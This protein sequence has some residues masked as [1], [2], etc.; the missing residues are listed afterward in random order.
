MKKAS[1][2]LLLLAFSLLSF[3]FASTYVNASAVNA[4]TA[5]SSADVQ[6]DQV[7][8]TIKIQEGALVVINDTLKLSPKAGENTVS[9]Q[10]FSLGFPFQ[11]G[12]NLDYCFAYEASDPDTWLDVELDTGLGRLGFYGVTVVFP[13]PG[14]N[15]GD[16][17][18]YNLTVIFVF[19]NLVSSETATL[20]KLDFPMY[21]SLTQN[22]SVC[23]VTVILPP[24]ASFT[25]S[26][27]HEKELDFNITTLGDSQIL[28]HPKKPS[29]SFEYEPAWLSF[30]MT[31]LTFPI[32]EFNEIEREIVLDQWGSIHISNSYSITNRGYDISNVKVGFPEGA[33]DLAVRDEMGSIGKLTEE[34]TVTVYLRET[35]YK[36]EAGKF[37]LSYH[38]PW[39]KYISHHNRLNYDLNFSFFERF[40]WTIGKLTV[41]IT[42]PQGA[43]FQSSNPLSPHSIEK[44][45]FQE[46]VTFAFFNVTPFEDLNFDVTYGYLV[47]WASF[48]P[49]LWMGVLII[50]ASAIA[51][52]WRAPKPPAVPMV[53]VPPEDL[54]SFVE[55]YK[56]KTRILSELESM[57]EQLRKGKIPRRRYKVRKKMLEGRLSTLS[58]DL[59]NLGEKIRTAGPKYANIM[60]QI[61]VAETMLEGVETDIRRVEARYRRGELSKGAYGKLIEEYHRRMERARTT[62]DGVLLRLREEIR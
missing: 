62:I 1:M 52:L 49:T 14:V 26:T 46:T 8:H 23:N 55:E 31:A 28:K 39:E 15:I 54:R 50:V 25:D 11:Y 29:E 59:S 24:K 5:S 56:G 47:F 6:V 22:A 37:F 16:G 9:L 36:D 21:P 13:E 20:L 45:V 17:E 48:Y 51:F 2:T 35:L 58:R 30:N 41:S 40:N 7:S 60:R 53:P 61:E 34:E 3:T 32:I 10:N 42:L 38:I 18:S 33:Y 57:E 4:K 19:S 27:F 44:N 43:E 12:F